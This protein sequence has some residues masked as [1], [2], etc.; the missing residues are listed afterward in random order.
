MNRRREM[1][2]TG[3]GK[4]YLYRDGTLYTDVTGGWNA[5]IGFTPTFV[6]YNNNN[7]AI[8]RYNFSET[9]VTPK[10][11][12]TNE[13]A[14]PYYPAEFT[15]SQIDLTPYSKLC[16]RYYLN[17]IST[18]RTTNR[19]YFGVYSARRATVPRTI[20]IGSEPSDATIKSTYI[21]SNSSSEGIMEIDLSDVSGSGYVG[22]YFSCT[23]ISQ[24]S[25]VDLRIYEIWLEK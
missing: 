20:V 12:Y 3:D 4:R 1:M 21:Y 19:L 5:S 14:T 16:M 22:V 7:Y 25:G 6:R 10:Y 15:V 13:L 23:N 11:W 24:G 17:G 2:L 18:V 9:T 8:Q